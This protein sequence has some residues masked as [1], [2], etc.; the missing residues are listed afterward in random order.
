MAISIKRVHKAVMS[1][2]QLFYC[3]WA[4]LHHL[5]Y[6]QLQIIKLVTCKQSSFCYIKIP[7][8]PPLI[9]V[10]L[11][12]PCSL[13]PSFSSLFILLELSHFPRCS[14]KSHIYWFLICLLTGG[15]SSIYEQLF[16]CWP[17]HCYVTWVICIFIR[18]CM[19][20]IYILPKW[21]VYIEGANRFLQN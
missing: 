14:Q 10:N 3:L 20:K 13:K 9:H 16:I 6:S 15:P 19:G 12:L 5:I 8:L 1:Q 18:I 7:R 21:E 11:D 17:L 2:A 4:A